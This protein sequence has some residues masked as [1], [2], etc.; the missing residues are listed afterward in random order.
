[1][2]SIKRDLTIGRNSDP[3]VTANGASEGADD[4]REGASDQAVIGGSKKE[5]LLSRRRGLNRG[6][7]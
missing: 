6:K 3:E 5:P 4:L 7:R 1:M 2:S